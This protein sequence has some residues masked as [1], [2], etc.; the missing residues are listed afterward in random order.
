MFKWSLH[1]GMVVNT[2][3]SQQK[4]LVEISVGAFLYGVCMTFPC[5]RGSLQVPRLFLCQPFPG[6]TPLLAQ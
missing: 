5:Q 1:V 2:V 6:C 3:T 4:V